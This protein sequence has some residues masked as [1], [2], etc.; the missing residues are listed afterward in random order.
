LVLTDSIPFAINRIMNTTEIRK[1]NRIA[2][3]AENT[4]A[5]QSS[6][7]VC[8]FVCADGEDVA[9]KSKTYKTL[10]GAEKFAQGWCK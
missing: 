7:I 6:F 5:G 8:C 2:R 9:L 10:K 3:I 4:Y 1:G